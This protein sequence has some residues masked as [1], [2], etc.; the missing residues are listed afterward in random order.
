MEV[1]RREPFGRPVAAANID[2]SS[3]EVFVVNI[4]R[5]GHSSLNWP[6]TRP[7]SAGSSGT[8][9]LTISASAAAA[10]GPDMNSIRASARSRAS[11]SILPAAI[12]A[13]P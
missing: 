7:L 5:S 8:D 12:A 3:V 9:S 4:A 11:A 13:S 6:R 10:A 2:G 1:Q